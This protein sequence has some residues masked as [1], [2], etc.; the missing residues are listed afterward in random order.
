[1][2]KLLSIV[3]IT[4]VL[5]SCDRHDLTPVI[6]NN[7]V[8][9]IVFD[10]NFQVFEDENHNFLIKGYPKIY[11][12]YIKPGKVG[13][14]KDIK[15]NFS[16]DNSD[17]KAQYVVFKWFDKKPESVTLL[18]PADGTRFGD[19]L[20]IKETDLVDNKVFVTVLGQGLGVGT[21]N[22][23]FESTWNNVVKKVSKKVQ[24]AL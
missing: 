3:A 8:S 6:D 15:M 22:I 17:I 14:S 18:S 4:V 10:Y 1:M 2:K 7:N 9:D 20:E 12:V 5:F 24:I 21:A 23:T 13:K 16:I 19:I 11:E